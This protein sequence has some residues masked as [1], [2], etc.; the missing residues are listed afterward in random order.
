MMLVGKKRVLIYALPS[1]ILVASAFYLLLPPQLKLSYVLDAA[2]LAEKDPEGTWGNMT[3]PQCGSELERII[4]DPDDPQ[5]QD[6]PWR[7]AYYCRQEDIFWV[8]DMPGWY[9]AGWYGPFNAFWKIR[10]TTAI[11][12]II[13]SGVGLVLVAIMDRGLMKRYFH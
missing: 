9:F 4:L 8:A 1:I 2:H 5:M 3:C 13:I 6:E 12:I 10:N 7:F 11:S